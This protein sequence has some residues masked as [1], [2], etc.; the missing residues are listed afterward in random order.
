[1][2]EL[3][4]AAGR[5]RY[6]NGFN[7]AALAAVAAGVAVYYALPQEWVKVL[8]GLGVGGGAYLGLAALRRAVEPRLLLA[9]RRAQP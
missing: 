2:R 6:L 7:V 5:Y 9:L 4:E 1:V 3:F 8:W